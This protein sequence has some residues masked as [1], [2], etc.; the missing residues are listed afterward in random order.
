[1]VMGRDG[2]EAAE[3]AWGPHPPFEVPIF[4]MTHR[5]RPDDAREG[6]TFHF[7][8]GFETALAR[9]RAAAGTQDV[10]LH[11]ASPI[12]QALAAG[13]LDELQLQLVPVLLGSG[14][15][16]F[17]ER[18]PAPVGLELLRVIDAPGAVHLKYRV[19]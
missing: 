14:R 5:P 4:V 3:A 16:L 13:A 17:E 15:R 6:T 10:A 8:D 7:V 2:Y 9:A 1:M 12:R 19:A 18:E 11:G